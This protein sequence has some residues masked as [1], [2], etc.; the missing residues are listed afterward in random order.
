MI[1][2]TLREIEKEVN[3]MLAD[4]DA[5]PGSKFKTD[6]HFPGWGDHLLKFK[7]TTPDFNSWACPDGERSDARLKKVRSLSTK[8]RLISRRV[9][10]AH[11][12]GQKLDWEM[13][14]RPMPRRKK[15]SKYTSEFNYFKGDDWVYRAYLHRA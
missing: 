1:N 15:T 5:P 9:M 4:V 12:P 3:E 2:K 7:L 13:V 14:E 11:F 6:S 10:G 8:I